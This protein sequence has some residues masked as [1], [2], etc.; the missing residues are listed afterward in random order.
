MIAG[1]AT[2][3]ERMTY[4]TAKAGLLSACGRLE[5]NIS[6]DDEVSAFVAPASWRGRGKGG[7]RGS[8]KGGG[9]RGGKGGGGFNG[10]CW[11]CGERGHIS[12]DCSKRLGDA[13]AEANFAEAESFAFV[14]E[15]QHDQNTF[16]FEEV[17][18]EHQ[19]R[20]AVE[21][22]EKAERE[23][24]LKRSMNDLPAASADSC[25]MKKGP[26]GMRI[27]QTKADG[28]CLFR[29][30]AVA[31]QTRLM[32]ASFMEFAAVVD[33]TE[34]AAVV[35]RCVVAELERWASDDPS[36]AAMLAGDERL[37]SGSLQDYLQLMMLHTTW[38]GEPELAAAAT[39][40]R[41]PIA[42]HQYLDGAW[43]VHVETGRSGVDTGV[44]PLRLLY[45]AQHYSALVPENAAAAPEP[46]ALADLFE[47]FKGVC[48]LPCVPDAAVHVARVERLVTP[49]GPPS[50]LESGYDSNQDTRAKLARDMRTRVESGYRGRNS[51]AICGLDSS[52]NTRK[53]GLAP[54]SA[55]V[56]AF[57]AEEEAAVAA[58]DDSNTELHGADAAC[59]LPAAEGD[60]TGVGAS[61]WVLDS[62][63]T[64]HMSAVRSDFSTYKTLAEPKLVGGLCVYAVGVGTVSVAVSTMENGVHYTQVE[65]VL[66][67][68]D[69]PKKS[70]LGLC[71]LFSQKIAQQH[72]HAFHYTS[73]LNFVRLCGGR[74]RVRIESLPGVNLYGLPLRVCEPA[75]DAVAVLA[76]PEKKMLWH[77]RLGH[78]H[79][80]G[81]NELLASL[82]GLGF[83]ATAPLDF[84]EACAIA[85]SK[86]AARSKEPQE[87]AKQML[88]KV[89]MDIWAVRKR[90]LGGQQYALSFVDDATGM[91]WLFYMRTKDE[92]LQKLDQFKLNVMLPARAR[93]AAATT[94]L[95][96]DND[97][98]FRSAA[99]RAASLKAGM[100]LEFAAPYSQHQNGVAERAWRTL[101][102]A[103]KSMLKASGRDADFWVLAMETAVYVRNRVHS[104]SVSGVPYELFW[105]KKAPL[106]HLRVFGCPAYVHVDASRRLKMQD[107]AVEG[108]FVGY[109]T[110][111]T[112]Y[113]VWLP[114][115]RRLIRSRNVVFDE[116]WRDAQAAQPVAVDVE[117][118]EHVGDVNIDQPEQPESSEPEPDEPTGPDE[119]SE[120][121]VEMTGRP[122]RERRPPQSWWVVEPAAA[123][124]YA[125]TV[126]QVV[127]EATNDKT[128]A[129]KPEPKTLRDALAIPEEA[130]QWQRATDEEY[131]SLQKQ[132]TWEL[133]KLPPGRRAIGCRW[134]YKRKFNR[135]GSVARYKARLVAKGF[136]QREGIDYQEVFAPVVKFTSIRVL[137]ALAAEMDWEL[138]QLDVDTAFLY[139]PVDEE[140][141]MQQP[142]GFQELDESG[143][144]LVCRLLKSLYGLKQSP[145]NWNHHLH[146]WLVE[147][148]WVQ[149]QADPGV[150]VHTV[151]DG[152]TDSSSSRVEQYILVLYVDDIIVGGPKLQFIEQLKTSIKETFKIKDLGA[153]S[154]CLGMEVSRDRAARTVE[155]T[156][157]KYIADMLSQYNMSDCKPVAVPMT[158]GTALLSSGELLQDSKPYQSLVGSLLYA[159][160]AT[161]PDIA[162]AVSKLARVMSKPEQLHWEL[163]KRVLRYLK[164]TEQL[165]LRFS[166]GGV[167]EPN[168]L[169]G[170]SDADWAGDAATRRSTTGY[171]FIINSAAVSW[172]S[173]L[174]PTVALSTAEAEYMA[175]C[176]A[177]QEGVFLRKLLL[178]LGFKQV[179]GTPLY[180]DNQ[181]CI[182]LS[183]N[184]ITSSRSKHIDIK[185]HFVREKVTEGQFEVLYCPTDEML[186]D[187]LTKA[188]PAEKHSSLTKAFMGTANL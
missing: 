26:P 9:R 39:V 65:N 171:V 168:M 44:E 81:M 75:D 108:V 137:L 68:P 20:L 152:T 116:A 5:I 154:W 67:V 188:L 144:S 62:G 159:A 8:G 183:K 164:G 119:S 147:H 46:E 53:L 61:C 148:G 103:A 128:P 22:F 123:L 69:M 27:V 17:P 92:A 140:I 83:S 21:A 121:A 70:K 89:H 51:P 145:R 110:E 36:V 112:A 134:V 50:E 48:E 133:T 47:A 66:H 173:K 59:G 109:D 90:S 30:V 28:A 167:D 43:A 135:D 100:V 160:V 88:E 11:T 33:S 12:R 182:A 142:E 32:A 118:E 162:N 76:A 143:E 125:A 31:H 151:K 7:G 79:G 14:A 55:V 80:A 49:S 179:I 157:R 104:R 187:P 107:K 186:A 64:Q 94:R 150:Y 4:A 77:R 82:P 91:I 111:S 87:K 155:L 114:E 156:Q 158:P 78:L 127:G 60:V 115:K 146:E 93:G 41:L 169:F 1:A 58:D 72:G 122:Q 185:Y 184:P 99:F 10:S 172:N 102:E 130:E 117:E 176:A 95:R 6:H 54:A 38:G 141:Y 126:E 71:R 25:S 56:C 57:V 163:A 73:E 29:A 45:K 165:G 180:E 63:C 132:L 98:V 161:R 120:Q 35:R 139:A 149:S 15:A 129:M 105:G 178:D 170:Y 13:A 138:E 3:A 34:R 86:Q 18:D 19:R 101:A 84:C 106:D 40:L 166:G 177:M 85:K 2:S 174:Q 136:S 37:Q 23:Q 113:L 52:Q 181:G 124:A 16:V 96:T 131:E 42:V 74:G 175:V 97:A 24:E 153:V